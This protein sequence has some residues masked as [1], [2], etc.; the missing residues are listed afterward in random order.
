[1]WSSATCTVLLEMNIYSQEK[2]ISSDVHVVLFNCECAHSL[3]DVHS[4]AIELLLSPC[5]CTVEFGTW[6]SN[7]LFKYK[8]L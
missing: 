3:V 5:V 1:M 6:P 2:I 8:S 7:F 4:Y